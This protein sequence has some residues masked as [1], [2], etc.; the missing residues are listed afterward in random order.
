MFRASNKSGVW[1]TSPRWCSASTPLAGSPRS[2][3]STLA[4]PL[5]Q[6]WRRRMRGTSL[7]SKSD[8]AGTPRLGCSQV[9]TPAPHRLATVGWVTHD[10]CE[11]G[12][13]LQREAVTKSK[14]PYFSI[15]IIFLY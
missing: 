5:D 15:N 8:K 9:A 1:Y 12:Y 10:I 3:Q 13:L 4:L 7:M 2:T 11:L 6:R 14:Q